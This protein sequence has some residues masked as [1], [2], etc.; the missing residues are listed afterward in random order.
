MVHQGACTCV[1]S[2]EPTLLF[3][4]KPVFSI[5]PGSQTSSDVTWLF[6]EGPS[7]LSLSLLLECGSGVVWHG[8]CLGS[9]NVAV[10]SSGTEPVSASGMWQW[11]HLAQN[12][13]G[14]LECG[15]GVIW[16]RTCLLLECGSGVI[17]HRMCLCSCA[18]VSAPGMWQWC[19]L[20][21][22]L[23]LLLECDSGVV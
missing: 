5:S 18:P 17:W 4:G 22:N 13:S 12:L 2:C 6:S 15:N 7:V 23:S 19:C 9:W 10:V 21:Q 1:P 16:H 8:T 3:T 20:A 11:C 14:L